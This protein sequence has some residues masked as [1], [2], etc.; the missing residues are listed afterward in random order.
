MCPMSVPE[1]QFFLI[2]Q[3]R[4]PIEHV[5]HIRDRL[6]APPTIAHVKGMHRFTVVEHAEG[7]LY[8]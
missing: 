2:Y 4:I 5:P 8:L 7:G 1:D 6:D 3:L